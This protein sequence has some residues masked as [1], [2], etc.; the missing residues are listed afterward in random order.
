VRPPKSRALVGA[1]ATVVLVGAVVGGAC[2]APSQT[3]GEDVDIQQVDDGFVLRLRNSE[4][5][6]AGVERELRAAG[7]DVSVAAVPFGRGATGTWVYPF[8]GIDP[9]DR[10]VL[11]LP[12]DHTGVVLFRATGELAESAFSERAPL[13][14]TGIESLAPSAA[15]AEINKLGYDVF[16]SFAGTGPGQLVFRF[17]A[18]AP[19]GLIIGATPLSD[20]VMMVRVSPVG[21][22]LADQDSIEDAQGDC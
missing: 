1:L 18:T 17:P 11:R 4:A 3:P 8:D 10:T 19:D 7:L 13:H 20:T 6:A 2:A 5:D 22:R 9:T 14:C 21:D 12:S 16:W 15:E